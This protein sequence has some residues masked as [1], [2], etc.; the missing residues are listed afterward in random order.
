MLWT[1]PKI[2]TPRRRVEE[3]CPRCGKLMP[4]RPR[5]APFWRGGARAMNIGNAVQVGPSGEVRVKSNSIVVAGDTDL[6]CCSVAPPTCLTYEC[7]S[8]TP[9]LI[10]PE[11]LGVTWTGID[12]CQGG[13]YAAQHYIPGTAQR[14]FR[15]TNQTVDPA[16]VSAC[17]LGSDDSVPGYPMQCGDATVIGTVEWTAYDNLF[18]ANDGTQQSYIADVLFYQ[19]ASAFGG[20]PYI[21]VGIF[22]IN[23]RDPISGTHVNALVS[24]EFF[25]A[26]TTF[27]PSPGQSLTLQNDYAHCGINDGIEDYANH[28]VEGVGFGRN[29]QATIETCCV[30]GIGSEDL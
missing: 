11:S 10:M 6:C 3:R 27:I 7:V 1:P 13:C 16:D 2:W 24:G 21:K 26:V 8:P 19:L 20:T 5:F 4:R 15:I 29:G 23:T 17:F 18:C 12:T 14:S 28:Y 9:L 30:E 22:P 25:S